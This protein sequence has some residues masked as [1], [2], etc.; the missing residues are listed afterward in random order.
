ML[1]IRLIRLEKPLTKPRIRH[2]KLPKG[3]SKN[4]P[5][6]KRRQISTK[7]LDEHEYYFF[8]VFCMNN[9]EL[10]LHRD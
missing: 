4:A 3:K 9:F 8:P 1:V 5:L 10:I 2:K 6:H 7:I